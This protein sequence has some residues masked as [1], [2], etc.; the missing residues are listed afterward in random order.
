[1]A[2]GFRT[3]KSLSLSSLGGDRRA[4]FSGDEGIEILIFEVLCF[5]AF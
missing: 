1:M 3:S 5:F 4:L 2:D